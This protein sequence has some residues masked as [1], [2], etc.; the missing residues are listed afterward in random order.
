MRQ[1]AGPLSVLLTCCFV[2]GHALPAQTK[3]AAGQL[4]VHPTN[5]RY[6]TDG[7]KIADGGW[8]RVQSAF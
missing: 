1:I 5:A 4:R 3:P 6:F 8:P 2:V 7:A